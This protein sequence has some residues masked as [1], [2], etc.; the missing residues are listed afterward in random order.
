MTSIVN[1]KSD[2]E[3]ISEIISDKLLNLAIYQLGKD[4]VEFYQE[5]FRKISQE[6]AVSTHRSPLIHSP[7]FQALLLSLRQ[8]KDKILPILIDGFENHHAY[9]VDN[10]FNC[11]NSVIG[12]Y[13]VLNGQESRLIMKTEEENE[14]MMIEIDQYIKTIDLSKLSLQFTL[15][16]QISHSESR[17]WLTSAKIIEI[18]DT[19]EATQDLCLILGLTDLKNE[20]IDCAIECNDA[21]KARLY[22]S[23]AN[24]LDEYARSNFHTGLI[25]NSQN[26]YLICLAEAI[27]ERVPKDWR[28]ENIVE[29]FDINLLGLFNDHLFND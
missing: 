14:Q 7:S 10:N 21:I 20:F 3:I 22:W 11:V 27:K 2:T 5:E 9:S 24:R 15:S 17:D 4:Q 18:I 23:I 28:E 19:P 1:R 8:N 29:D 25:S 26:E 12:I 13:D 16:M 6:C